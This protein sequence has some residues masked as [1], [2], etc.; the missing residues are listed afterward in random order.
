MASNLWWLALPAAVV[1]LIALSFVLTKLRAP[2]FKVDGKH[3]FITGGSTG[4]GLAIAKKY[5]RAGAKVSIVARRLEQ[6]EAAKTEIEA[7]NKHATPVFIHSCDV[8]DFGGMQTAVNAAVTHHGRAIDHVVCSAGLARPG[9]FLDTDVSVFHKMMDL[10]YFGT[11]HAVKAALPSMIEQD[12]GGQ[13]VLVSSG[14]ALVSWIGYA[15]YSASKY[16]VRGL[17]DALR[18]ELKVHNIRVSIFYPGN[19]DS[20]GYVEEEKTKPIETKAIEG[21]SELIHPDA[22][23]QSLIDGISDGQY[24]ITNELMIFFLRI[25]ANGVAP[26]NNTVLEM[27]LFPLVTVIQ[28]GFGFFM[29]F[30][31]SQAA[32]QKKKDKKE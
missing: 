23:A 20:P 31:V 8:T 22:V 25:I 14:L 30:T 26:R 1:G 11:L 12:E 32:K 4:L 13:V 29:D 15:Q 24:S 19:I 5:A 3:V 17:A 21:V 27:V 18:N 2:G 28:V 16:A 9:Y 10:N 6:L 7:V